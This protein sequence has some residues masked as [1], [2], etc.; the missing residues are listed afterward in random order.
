MAQ[1]GLP[2]WILLEDANDLVSFLEAT[3]RTVPRAKWAVESMLATQR[4]AN[5]AMF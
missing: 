1:G 3:D 4:A 2:R 5:E